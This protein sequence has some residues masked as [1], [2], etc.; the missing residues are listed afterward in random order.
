MIPQS[1]QEA[2]YTA[3]QADVVLRRGRTEIVGGVTSLRPV[4]R[5]RH[6]RFVGN[7]SYSVTLRKVPTDTGPTTAAT[8][9]ITRDANSNGVVDFRDVGPQTY[10][11]AWPAMTRGAADTL[12]FSLTLDSASRVNKVIDITEAD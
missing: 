3:N 11:T 4:R 2:S 8:D 7:G 10:G 5:I 9:I 12:A 1:S 6:L